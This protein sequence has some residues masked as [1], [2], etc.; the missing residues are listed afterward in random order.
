MSV[1]IRACLLF[2]ALAIAACTRSSPTAPSPPAVNGAQRLNVFSATDVVTTTIGGVVRDRDTGRPIPDVA[3]SIVEPAIDSSITA[4]TDADGTYRLSGIASTLFTVRFTHRR[5]ETFSFQYSFR[6]GTERT[7]LFT[8]LTPTLVLGGP[9][10]IF[11]EGV[12][13]ADQELIRQGIEL[14]DTYFPAAVGRGVLGETIIR[15]TLTPPQRTGT[16][17][18]ANGHAIDVYASTQGWQQAGRIAKLKIMVHEYFHVLQGEVNWPGMRGTPGAIWMLEG[19]A[20][21]VGYRA[22]IDS[23]LVSY[24]VVRNCQMSNVTF[25]TRLPAL[26]TLEGQAFNNTQG[27]TYGLAWL[28]VEKSTQRNLG[29]LTLYWLFGGTWQRAFETAFGLAL[30]PFYEAFEAE[31]ADYRPLRNTTCNF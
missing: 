19:A 8:Q 25:G 16:S 21:Y 24:D 15:T 23:G 3:V 12:A 30:E 5:Y 13:A 10:F 7:D 2:A 20:E 31:R 1:A 17:A 6:L 22:V 14:A 11:E 27:A 29:N 9:V 28:A 26:S 4:I 18:Q